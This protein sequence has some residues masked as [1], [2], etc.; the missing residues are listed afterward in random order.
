M[1]EGM[2]RHGRQ[3]APNP[4]FATATLITL[5][6]GIG[7]NTAVFSV[8][9][10]VILKPL[11]YPEPEQLISVQ[12]TAPGAPGLISASGALRLSASMY[13]TF[14]DHNR[15]FQN[16]GAWKTGTATVTGMGD[17]EDVRVIAVTRGLLEALRVMPEVGRW[18]SEADQ[19]PG[20]PRVVM[21]SY[22]YWQRKFG[23]DRGVLGRTMEVASLPRQVVGVMPP[24]FRVVETESEL[25]VPF[26]FDR[27]QLM[28]PGFAFQGI[29]R[30]RPGVTIQEA[31]ADLVRLLPV[32]MDSWP[33]PPGISQRNWEQ[34]R[35]TPALRPLKQ[36]VVGWRIGPG[37]GRWREVI[38]VVQDVYDNGV[39]EAAPATV[40]W[41]AYLDN[42]YVPGS[43][44]VARN[45]AFTVRSSRTGSVDLLRQV[46]QAVWQVNSNLS[47]ASIQ[48]LADLH[49]RSLA[50]TS[51]TLVMLAIAGGL[52]LVLG[53]IGIYGVLAY[54]MTRRRREVG[55]R[56]ALG[57]QPAL[58]KLM[59]VR[60][61]LM[62]I[63]IGVAAGLGRRRDCRDG[64][65]PCCLV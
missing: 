52:A 26:Q 39:Q 25:I 32:W 19:A 29:A 11:P 49:N 33:A 12:H 6:L 4:M 55:I 10:G 63:A 28:I 36:E 9:N 7:A 58:V 40:Y 54:T 8:I 44:T 37:P 46:E 22:G 23:G 50:R 41:P 56:M 43:P 57:A 21:L 14:A 62:L 13:F 35:I 15:S 17:P 48:T 27:A 16:I 47:M 5:A 45:V 2:V 42:V 24:G 1:I 60:Q 51:F 20:A 59:F 64:C 61:G 65:R 53:V 31:S 3:T 34:W 30:L 38:G 18:L